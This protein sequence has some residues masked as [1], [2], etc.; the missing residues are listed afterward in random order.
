MT[1]DWQRILE[2]KRAYRHAAASRP[3][4]EKLRMLEDLRERALAIRNAASHPHSASSVVRE[5][6]ARYRPTRKA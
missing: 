5:Q 6:S 2:S 4:V 3:I 1:F